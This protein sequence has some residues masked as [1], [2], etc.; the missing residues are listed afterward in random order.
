[1]A[2]P[3]RLG[4][5][6]RLASRSP[7]V[8]AFGGPAS[9]HD[10]PPAAAWRVGRSGLGARSGAPSM[11]LPRPCTA[12]RALLQQPELARRAA[13]GTGGAP[14]PAARRGGG[15]EG[16]RRVRGGAGRQ[17]RAGAGGGQDYDRR[18]RPAG[19]PVAERSASGARRRRACGADILLW[20]WVRPPTHCDSRRGGRAQLTLET[21][22][23]GRQAN[24]AVLVTDGETVRGAPRRTPARAPRRSEPGRRPRRPRRWCTPRRAAA[25]SL[26]ATA[27]SCRCRCCTPSASA[28][29]G[30]PGARAGRPGAS[31][32]MPVGVARLL[33]RARGSPCAYQ[34][35]P[36]A[37]H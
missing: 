30:R 12:A 4:G 11:R 36:P 10:A 13:G 7:T 34:T 1:M 26:P 20:Q 5:S 19:A 37:S 32:R 24:G 29:R 15:Q 27:P 25:R 17:R 33:R 28:R 3:P 18:G 14:L 21:G 6:S 16:L 23:V 2:S 8:I 22:E 9:Q 35:L 31:P